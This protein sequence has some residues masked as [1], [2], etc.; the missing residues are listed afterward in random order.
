MN[1][2]RTSSSVMIWESLPMRL[3]LPLAPASG[4]AKRLRPPTS[5]G[6]GEGGAGGGIAAAVAARGSRRV[7]NWVGATRGRRQAVQN[8]ALS[9][10]SCPQAWHFTF[11]T[12]PQ[13]GRQ[14]SR[15][16]S[17]FHVAGGDART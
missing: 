17:R 2:E 7:G 9:A 6:A 5:P 3:A 16:S 10:L 12:P 1:A 8:N 13:D 4:G 15:S 11:S 14:D